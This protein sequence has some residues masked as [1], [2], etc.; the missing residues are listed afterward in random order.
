MNWYTFWADVLVTIH[1]GIVSFVLFGQVITLVGVCLGW[2]WVRNF[3][4]RL[5]HL[6]TIGIV[7]V[8][9]L[10]E[11]ECP[12]TTWEYNLRIAAGEGA[13][14]GSFIGRLM[15]DL[16]FYDA[17]GREWIFTLCYCLFGLLVLG[18]FL[19]APPRWPWKRRAQEAAATPQ[20]GLPSPHL[21]E[22]IAE[23]NDAAL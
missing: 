23:K 19:I 13:A 12:F 17:Q 11:Y 21:P 6:V 2:Q 18:T 1:L 22:R 16:L 10:F 4:F 3:W 20:Q 5:A 7:V 9:S 15:H 8:E 14:E